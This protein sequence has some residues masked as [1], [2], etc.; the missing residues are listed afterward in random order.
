MRKGA[1][2]GDASHRLM[3]P[4]G[5]SGSMENVVFKGECRDLESQSPGVRQPKT[6]LKERMSF[7]RKCVAFCIRFC[8]YS[9]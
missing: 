2:R 3:I 6:T 4:S 7:L 8:N 5:L 9:R 1:E